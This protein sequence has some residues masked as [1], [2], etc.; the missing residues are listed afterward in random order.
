MEGAELMIECPLPPETEQKW[1]LNG[2]A[3]PMD[4]VPAESNDAGIVTALLHSSKARLHQAGVYTCSREPNAKRIRLLEEDTL[5]ALIEEDDC[6]T[7]YMNTKE[8]SEVEADHISADSNTDSE[9]DADIPS[10]NSDSDDLPLLRLVIRNSPECHAGINS[11]II[12][13]FNNSIEKNKTNLRGKFIRERFV[14]SELDEETDDGVRVLYYDINRNLTL[15]C[16]LTTSDRTLSYVWEKNGVS[17]DQVPELKSRYRLESEG[18]TFTLSVRAT[19]DDYGNYSCAL[20]GQRGQ[21]EVRGRPAARLPDHSNVVEGQK[22]KLQCRVVGRPYPAVT[23]AYNE[24]DDEEATVNSAT[25]LEP[26]NRIRFENNDQGVEN[27][28]LVIEAAQRSD[29]GVYW[30]RAGG[31]GGVGGVG[32][33]ADRTAL[34]VKDMYAALWPFLGI[35]AEVFVLCAI[36]LVY[37]KRR[38]KPEMDDSDTDNHDQKKS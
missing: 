13:M 25:P 22:L 36:I 24:T 34:R 26:G 11:M 10:S 20:G 14:F 3:P 38:T 21:W 30:C 4:M 31:V 28:T 16:S 12:H 18:A 2:G 9:V 33:S 32:G 15:N 8:E 19:E 29:A 7:D 27:G 23:W 5:R 6:E 1:R 37:E 35:C 17:V